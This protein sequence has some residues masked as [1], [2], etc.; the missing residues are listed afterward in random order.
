MP[1]HIETERLLLR[2]VDWKDQNDFFEMD[3]DPEVHRFIEQSPL[4]SIDQ[5]LPIIEMLKK[6]YQENGIARWAVIDKKSEE[7]IGWCGLKFFR[8]VLNGHLDFYE[9]GYR[10]KQKHWGKGYATE[11]AKAVLDY[12]FSQLNLKTVFAF[13]H[14]ENEASVHVLSKLG[15]LFE[16]NFDYD[17]EVCKWFELTKNRWSEVI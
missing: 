9:L 16:E 14:L 4:T 8:E 1:I 10:F 7:C 13:T 17:G 5:E 2:E 3:S 12:G 11:S 15:F 6:Q